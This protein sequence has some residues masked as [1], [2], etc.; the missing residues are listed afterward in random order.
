[1]TV[2]SKRWKKH[3]SEPNNFPSLQPGPRLLGQRAEREPKQ[4]TTNLLTGGDKDQSSVRPN[5]LEFAE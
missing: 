5:Q 2:I 4:N 3:Q 1:M